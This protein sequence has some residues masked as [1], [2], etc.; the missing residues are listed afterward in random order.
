M[1]ALR[2]GKKDEAAAHLAA[3]QK[4]VADPKLETL[5]VWDRYSLANAARIAERTLAAEIDAD[6]GRYPQAIAALREAVTV[7][8]NTPYD[9]PP[10][11]HSPV[12]QSLGAVLLAAG[13][14][15]EAES[16]YREELKRNPDNGW[17]LFGLAQAQ[18]AQHKEA[19]A[20]ATDQAFANA[21]KD[22]DVKLSSSR[23]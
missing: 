13:Q 15:A 10:A 20:K 3:L 1:A 22:A 19:E 6:A 12:R 17:S 14:P 21:W 9:E 4:G 23:F 16:A 2:L 11:W 8:D 18:R 7:E 5:K